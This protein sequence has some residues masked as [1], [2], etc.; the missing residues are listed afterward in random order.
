MHRKVGS[1]CPLVS[2]VNVPEEDGQATAL[3]HAK[4][5]KYLH[6]SEISQASRGVHA[7]LSK[8]YLVAVVVASSI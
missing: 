7:S 4:A 1:K 6:R 8:T 5:S 2:I 3:V